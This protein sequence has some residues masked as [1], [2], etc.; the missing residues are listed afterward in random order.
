VNVRYSIT[1]KSEK[2]AYMKMLMGCKPELQRQYNNT[3]ARLKG[4]RTLEPYEAKVSCTVLKGLETGN[5]LRLLN[6]AYSEKIIW[7]A[8]EVSNVLGAGFLEKVYEN[9]KS[10]ELVRTKTNLCGVSSFEFVVFVANF[11][12]T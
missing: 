1:L 10:N 11:F 12:H 6:N 3:V 8:F 7:V 2:L 9:E 4:Y 5:G